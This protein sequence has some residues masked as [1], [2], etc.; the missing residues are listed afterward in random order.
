MINMY[1][2]SLKTILRFKVMMK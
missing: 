2:G 1:F